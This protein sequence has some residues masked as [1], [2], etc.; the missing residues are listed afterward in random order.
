MT[1]HEPEPLWPTV[2]TS[3]L[4]VRILQMVA[5]A[6]VEY[7]MATGPRPD[8]PD[9]GVKEVVPDEIDTGFRLVGFQ[10]TTCGTAA[11]VKVTLTLVAAA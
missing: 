1:G 3:E 7:V 11:T 5:G 6:V 9:D 10:L 8:A 4:A 2:M